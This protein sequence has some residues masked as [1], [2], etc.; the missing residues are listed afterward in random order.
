MRKKNESEVSLTAPE[1][2]NYVSMAK[3]F[4]CHKSMILDK[5]L[6]TTKTLFLETFKL[7]DDLEKADLKFVAEASHQ[8]LGEIRGISLEN[9]V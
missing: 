8:I 7:S 1:N 3:T 6:S 5:V 4:E 2:D 9:A